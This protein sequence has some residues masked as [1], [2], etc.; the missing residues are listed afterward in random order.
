MPR[1]SDLEGELALLESKGLLRVPEGAEGVAQRAGAGQLMACSNDYLG[2]ASASVS[3]ETSHGTTPGAGASR[4]VFGTTASHLLLERT[5]AEWTSTSSALTFTSGYAANLGALQSLAD[6]G[7]VL[8]SDRLNHASIIDGC[9]LSKAPTRIVEH[10]DLQAVETA[11]KESRHAS[12]RWVVSE[13]YFSMDGTT[14]DLV[15]LRELCDRHDAYLVVDEAHALGVFGPQ[16]AG[17]CRQ[18]GVRPDVLVA[19]FGKALGAQGAAVCGS[20]ALQHWLYNRARSF[21]FSTA[22][23]PWLCETVRQ[24]I[25]W[26]RGAEAERVRLHAAASRLREQLRGAGL[27]LPAGNHGPIVPVLVGGNEQVL[28][29]R[30]RLAERGITAQAIRPPTVPEG[31][32]RLRVTVSSAMSDAELDRLAQGLIEA[33]G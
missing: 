22:L 20:E 25:D 31:T 15:G 24:R 14:P 30:S 19:T 26:I 6:E 21:V 27:Q 32:A 1:L 9:R 16:G 13:S 11:L 5:L 29:V 18:H 3:R 28:A 23:S 7:A 17:L 12:A 8:I 10:C 33:V 4:L 2:L